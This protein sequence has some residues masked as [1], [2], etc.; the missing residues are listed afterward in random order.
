MD[1]IKVR[2]T[3]VATRVLDFETKDESGKVDKIDGLQVY[4]LREPSDNEVDHGWNEVV[5]DKCFIPKSKR[6]NFPSFTHVPMECDF[7]Y[8]MEGVKLR[9]S[10]II[11]IAPTPIT[12]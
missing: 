1:E 5:V 11:E 12:K 4:F 9:L 6:Q 3:V 10:K 8:Q 2:N 7:I